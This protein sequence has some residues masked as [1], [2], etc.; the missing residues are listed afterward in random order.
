MITGIYKIENKVNGRVYIGQGKEILERW[1]KHISMLKKDKHDNEHL[2]ESWNKYGCSNFSFEIVCF[3]EPEEMNDLEI[4][5]IKEYNSFIYD[6]NSNGYNKTRGG[7][8]LNGRVGD[9]AIKKTSIICLNNMTVFDSIASAS[10]QLGVSKD[11]I[12]CVISNRKGYKSA[13][14]DLLTGEK[15]LW[16][17]YEA[18]KPQDFYDGLF[19]K[20]KQIANRYQTNENKTRRIRCINTGDVFNSVKEAGEWGNTNNIDKQIRGEYKSS[21]KHPK[22]GEKLMWEYVDGH[23][24]ARPVEKKKIYYNGVVYECIADC[25]KEIGIPYNTVKQ[26]LLGLITMPAGLYNSGL[27][28]IGVENDIKIREDEN[29]VSKKVYCDGM[30]FDSVSKANEHYNL[31]GSIGNYLNGITKMPKKFK[32]LGL[33]Y[34]EDYLEQNKEREEM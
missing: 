1:R 12:R 3:C 25:A 20:K 9:N 22:T 15:L 29:G 13:G 33:M 28:Y 6:D 31:S 18:D 8:G 17:K 27:Y 16:A 4:K 7:N 26:Y 2:Q 10:E 34:Y 5:Y 24:T 30:V 23:D 32:N 11:S 21:G 14:V 19:E